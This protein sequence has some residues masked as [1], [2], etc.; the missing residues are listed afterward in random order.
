MFEN[1]LGQ[2]VTQL[3]RD[4]IVRNSLPPALLFTGPEASGKLTAALEAA[5][6]LSCMETGSW[7]C[8]CESCRRH[9]D[10]SASGCLA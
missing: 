1:V 2:P 8:S 5:R 6:T 9:K 4:E 7:T 10:L 3:L